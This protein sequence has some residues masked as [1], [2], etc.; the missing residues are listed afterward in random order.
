VGAL[1][2]WTNGKKNLN[3]KRKAT[4]KRVLRLPDLDLAK[5]TVFNSL[6]SPDSTRAYAHAIDDFIAWYCA[7]PRLAFGKHVVLRYRIKLE[8][9]LL[10]PATI[11]VR[12]AAVRRLA[13]EAA[14]SGLLSPEL[15]AGIQRVKGAKK[16][17]V[18]LGNWLTVDECRRLLRAPD[19]QTLKGKR[20]RAVLA[21][22]LG[23]GLRRAEVAKLQVRD[24]QQREEH[25]AVVDLIGKGRHIRTVPVPD[26]VKATLDEWTRAAAIADGRLFRCVNRSGAIW[27]DGITEKVVWHI[28]KDSAKRAGIQQLAPHDCLILLFPRP[29]H[30]VFRGVKYPVV[31]SVVDGTDACEVD[32][33]RTDREGSPG[34]WAALE[35]V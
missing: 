29:R 30:D 25:W 2:Q 14:D 33:G 22:L 1:W 12:L 19:E 4:P 18:R 13:Y 32:E 6:G 15:A 3:R 24:L 31:F 5:R 8:S 11:N 21:M 26:W 7:E 9:R 28:V 10:A 17:G 16:L 34:H 35:G 20:D 23:C 27:G